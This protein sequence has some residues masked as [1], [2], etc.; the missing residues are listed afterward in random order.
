VRVIGVDGC[1]GGWL[2][3]CVDDAGPSWTW[4]A[5]I[6][7]VLAAPADAIAI[8]IPIGLPDAGTRACDLEARRLLGPRRASVFA[9]PTRPVL[10]C[11]TYAEAR[12]V[13]ASLGGPSMS[14]QA[15]GIVRAV[16]AVDA[17]LTA[18]DSD[19]IV[20]A[21]PELA[22]RTLAGHDL[23]SKKTPAGRRQRIDALSTVWPSVTADLAAAPR[24]AAP[25]DALDAL[26]CAWV[27]Q[28]WADGTAKVL[29][30]GS[31]DTRRLPM[32][33]AY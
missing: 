25:D 5:D 11:A 23:A 10:D 1:R 7:D 12:V 9:A 19:R 32:R 29:G 4:T 27:A 33:I 16:R 14:A 3:A 13:L 2:A 26:A 22:F 17:H 8:D 15:F 24:P 21:H 30:D 18:E 20:E 6:A 31:R 28:R